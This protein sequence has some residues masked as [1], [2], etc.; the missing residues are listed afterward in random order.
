MRPIDTYICEG[1]IGRRPMSDEERKEAF[2]EEVTRYK[3]IKWL[4]ANLDAKYTEEE[5]A[6]LI[7][8]HGKGEISIKDT[9]DSAWNGN[10]TLV[11]SQGA[12]RQMP[13]NLKKI[14]SLENISIRYIGPR[15]STVAMPPWWPDTISCNNGYDCIADLCLAENTRSL[16][17]WK[18][19]AD[20]SINR[21][22]LH[23]YVQ[24]DNPR[25]YVSIPKL[26]ITFGHG[27]RHGMTLDC[28]GT[29]DYKDTFK[30]LRKENQGELW[31]GL[32]EIGDAWGPI[33]GSNRRWDSEYGFASDSDRKDASEN[34]RRYLEEQMGPAVTA[35]RL[36][37]VPGGVSGI[38]SLR[39]FWV[40][41][42]INL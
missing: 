21:S 23:V 41:M 25:A 17:G 12:V 6:R 20:P 4:A 14:R 10:T 27:L 39:C 32:P 11:M 13:D 5:A 22:A 18:F 8:F 16:A 15:T 34:I 30:G 28:A 7:E 37:T 29:W 26:D 33:L 2:Q 42:T 1:L 9:D 40:K 31:I 3:I 19:D 35:A 24:R 38:G 36:M